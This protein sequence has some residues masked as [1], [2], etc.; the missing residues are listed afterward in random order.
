MLLLLA[1]ADPETTLRGWE[2]VVKG[3]GIAL[4]ITGMAIVFAALVVITVFIGLVPQLLAWLDPILPK[5]HTHHAPPSHEE[6]SA[7]D[8]ERVVAAIGL[9][10][11]TEMQN[12]L[13]KSK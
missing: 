2:A 5:M 11:H 9:V 3:N 12:V 7:T 4:S 13:N 1:Q 6:Q 10:L 8:R